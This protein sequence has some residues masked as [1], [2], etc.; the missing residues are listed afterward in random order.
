MLGRDCLFFSTFSLLRALFSF[1]FSRSFSL[2]SFLFLSIFVRQEHNSDINFLT[3]WWSTGQRHRL[4]AIKS[5]QVRAILQKVQKYLTL[6][7]S[8]WWIVK[9]T[10]VELRLCCR[11]VMSGVLDVT[12]QRSEQRWWGWWVHKVRGLAETDRGHTEEPEKNWIK[13]IWSNAAAKV[14]ATLISL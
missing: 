11:W 5:K 9:L 10:G 6:S 14:N 8:L 12:L 7:T 3:F 13:N 1:S 4:K 2:F